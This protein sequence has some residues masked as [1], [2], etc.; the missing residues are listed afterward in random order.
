[1]EGAISGHVLVK[2]EKNTLPFNKT[3]N[4]LSVFGYDAAVP[5]T[6]NADILFQLGYTSSPEM[7]K[8]VL[9]TEQHFNQA[10]R[11]GTIVSGGRAAANGP[12]YMSD[13]RIFQLA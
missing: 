6:K 4:M 2:N 3:P 9:G 12:P 10:A 8:A 1:M 5:D 11:G 7:G 13:V